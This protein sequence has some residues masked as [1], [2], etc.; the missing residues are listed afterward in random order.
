MRKFQEEQT[1]SRGERIGSVWVTVGQVQSTVN[2]HQSQ[3]LTNAEQVQAPSIPGKK[4][5]RG[6]NAV[7]AYPGE[8]RWSQSLLVRIKH[9]RQ[10]SDLPFFYGF[11]LKESVVGQVG[12]N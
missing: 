10:S 5:G 3:P 11:I 7:D 12:R 6:N 1:L 8:L 4:G 9:H 2:R